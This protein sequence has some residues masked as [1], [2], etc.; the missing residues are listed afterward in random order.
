MPRAR[1]SPTD[2]IRTDAAWSTSMMAFISFGYGNPIIRFD[3]VTVAI[4]SALR[5]CRNQACGLSAATA[6]MPAQSAPK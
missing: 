2:V 6:D 5:A 4:S 1:A 3:G